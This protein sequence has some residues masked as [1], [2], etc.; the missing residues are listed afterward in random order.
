MSMA[1]TFVWRNNIRLPGVRDFLTHMYLAYKLRAGHVFSLQEAVAMVFRALAVLV[2]LLVLVLISL[3]VA[4][5]AI[6]H[7]DQ[8]AAA[9]TRAEIWDLDFLMPRVAWST[10]FASFWTR[11]GTCP[12]RFLG[13]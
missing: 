8:N 12:R 1:I 9:C 10:T 6:E 2:A 13:R 7:E 4:K 3:W 5:G 11:R